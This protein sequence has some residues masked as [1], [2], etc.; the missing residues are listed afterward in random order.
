M[1]SP[2]S[3]IRQIDELVDEAGED[4]QDLIALE[5]QFPPPEDEDD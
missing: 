3:T 5:T 2:W 1:S 4:E